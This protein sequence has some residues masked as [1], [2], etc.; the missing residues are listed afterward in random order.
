MQDFEVLVVDNAGSDNIAEL[1]ASF[2]DQRIRYV[3][4]DSNLGM[5]NNFNRCLELARGKYITLISSDEMMLGVDSLKRRIELL[6]NGQGI[7]YVWCASD[8]ILPD[9][10]IYSWDQGLPSKEIMPASEALAGLLGGSAKGYRITTVIVRRSI[11]EA[12]GYRIPLVHSGDMPMGGEWLLWSRNA[13]CVSDVLHRNIV[14]DTHEHD[15]Y[16]R[17]APFLGERDW[18]M[19]KLIDKHLARLVALDL[20][21]MRFE[22]TILSRL[23]WLLLRQISRQEFRQFNF[24]ATFALGRWIRLLAYGLASVPNL[25]LFSIARL[26]STFA[27][28]AWRRAANVNFLRRLVGKSPRSI[29]ESGD[30]KP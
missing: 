29:V 23:T 16:G 3:R 15:F 18:W 26:V 8:N 10:S 13:A 30:P 14:H 2:G 11:L 12:S 24:Y 5:I 28:T 17:K 6:E 1:V 22:L 21:W 19:L 4:N 9:G 27:S 25:L 20:P 7:D